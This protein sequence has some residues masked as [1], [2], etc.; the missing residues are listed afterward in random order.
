MALDCRPAVHRYMG[1]SASAPPAV[2]SI[3]RGH[4]KRQVVG[5]SRAGRRVIWIE[6]YWRGP[7]DAPILARPY[8]IGPQN[9][10]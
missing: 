3:V 10:A 1:G 2:Q 9:D 6:P 8:K 4:F 7:E 5:I